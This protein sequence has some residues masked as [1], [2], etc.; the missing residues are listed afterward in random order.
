MLLFTW[1]YRWNRYG[2]FDL[3]VCVLPIH[4]E[5]WYHRNLHAIAHLCWRNPI[6]ITAIIYSISLHS[7]HVRILLFFFSCGFAAAFYL[8]KQMLH[9]YLGCNIAFSCKISLTTFCDITP[10]VQKIYIYINFPIWIKMYT[11]PQKLCIPLGPSYVCCSWLPARLNHFP[12]DYF[13]GILTR[14]LSVKENIA[15]C[16]RN[17]MKICAWLFIRP[18]NFKKYKCNASYALS[19]HLLISL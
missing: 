7:E 18:F 3:F 11:A 8:V 14:H 1:L 6:S 2:T 12:Q 16:L 9:L 13:T 10:L 5:P 17:Q 19:K 4:C 15:L